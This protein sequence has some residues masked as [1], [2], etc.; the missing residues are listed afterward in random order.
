[1]PC[2]CPGSWKNKLLATD[3][4]SPLMKPLV[5]DFAPLSADAAACAALVLTPAGV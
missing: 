5:S 2:L 1:M 4:G 3:P